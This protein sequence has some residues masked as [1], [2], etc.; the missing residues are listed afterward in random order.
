VKPALLDVNVLLALT[1]PNHQHHSQ[2]QAWFAAH[3]SQGWATC[4]VTQLG[5]V[6]LSSNP[7]FTSN[8]VSPR[9]AAILLGA[10][11]R[12]EAHQFL[13]SPSAQEPSIYASVL[14]HQQV[15]DAWLVEVARQNNCSLVTLD[16]RIAAHAT[17]DGLVEI[18]GTEV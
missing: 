10:W 6:R 2:A 16:K 7:A 8:A 14:G 4:A 5:F 17:A 3:A 9:N 12:H 11:T 15:N 1:W 13:Q 18:I